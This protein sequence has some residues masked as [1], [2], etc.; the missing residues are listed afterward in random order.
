[1]ISPGGVDL[2]KGQFT[3]KYWYPTHF[4]G[5]WVEA[6][7]ICNS[8]DL[9]L[10]TI[11]SVDESNVFLS[12]YTQ[13]AALFDTWTHIGAVATIPRSATDWYWV[14]S[15]EKVNFP[16]KFGVGLPDNYGGNEA[17][18]T[19][20]L[21]LGSYYFNDLKC[22]EHYIMKFVCQSKLFDTQTTPATPATTQIAFS[23]TSSPV[24][25]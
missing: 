2:V 4:R 16:L 8:Y 15:T 7:Q 25:K 6:Q 1:M 5:T 17:C 19:L 3:K 10:V 14:G 18:L 13:N 21:F 12:L 24:C 23:T 11:D 9:E 20:G 22:Y